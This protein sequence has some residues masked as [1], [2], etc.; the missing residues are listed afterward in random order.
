VQIGERDV[1]IIGAGTAGLAVSHALR[2]RGMPHQILERGRVGETWRSERW[3]SFT[4]VTP[5]WAT[6]LPGL[7]HDAHDP[8]G[9]LGLREWFAYLDR[10]IVRFPPPIREGVAV[11][12][13][14]GRAQGGFRLE[15]SEGEIDA[16]VVVVATGFFRTPV[17]P[18]F[19]GDLP[20]DVRQLSGVQYRN[21]ASLPAGAVLVVGTGQSGSQIAEELLEAGREVYLSLGRVGRTP[22]R[23]RGRDNLWWRQQPDFTAGGR[24]RPVSVSQMTGKDGGRD[25]NLHRFAGDGMR[26]LGRI[27]GVDNGVVRIAPD[28]HQRLADAD[29]ADLAFRRAVDAFVDRTGLDAPLDPLPDGEGLRDGFAQPLRTSLDLAA[30]GV[31]TVIWATGF[32][33]DCS[34]IDL[35]VV[36]PDGRPIAPGGV[37]GIPGLYFAGMRWQFPAITTLIGGLGPEAARIAERIA[38]YLRSGHSVAAASVTSASTGA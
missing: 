25:L 10:Y 18:P 2:E 13:V 6:A 33:P 15:T 19:A 20:P 9:F 32:R 5:T 27:D 34:W 28:L 21:P 17:I 1:V 36:D 7:A 38:E 30:A 22:R 12:Q 4:M 11:G 3:D 16:R 26:L 23:Y 8:D 37:T 24:D 31:T 35:P 14:R 29:A